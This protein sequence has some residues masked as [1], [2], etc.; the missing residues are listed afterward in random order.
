MNERR[1]HHMAI[2]HSEPRTPIVNRKNDKLP[3]CKINT[4]L[5]GDRIGR[6]LRTDQEL[7][8]SARSAPRVYP[9][10]WRHPRVVTINRSRYNVF[11]GW[12]QQ[13]RSINT[14]FVSGGKFRDQLGELYGILKSCST[15]S[16]QFPR[17][18]RSRCKLSGCRLYVT[19]LSLTAWTDSH[20][21]WSSQ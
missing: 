15:D 8:L 7:V 12:K 11:A 19:R 13:S 4:S 10:R 1:F 2:F 17:T 9:T 14:R 5:N 20:S 3:I 16:K 6:I 21:G 18:V